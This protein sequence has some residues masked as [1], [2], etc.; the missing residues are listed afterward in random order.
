MKIRVASGCEA[1]LLYWVCEVCKF[2][3]IPGFFT[4]SLSLAFTIDLLLTF[5]L[6]KDKTDH[7]Q[8][9]NR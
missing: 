6:I 4:L 3:F 8:S 5:M 1:T 2:Y 7:Y 9:I